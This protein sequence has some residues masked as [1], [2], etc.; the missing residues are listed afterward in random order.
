MLLIEAMLDQAVRGV[1]V[2][3]DGVCMALPCGREKDDLVH[4]GVGGGQGGEGS[5]VNQMRLL[6]MEPKRVSGLPR[7]GQSN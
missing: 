6:V 3:E 4:L 2:G 1:E 5:S 7:R